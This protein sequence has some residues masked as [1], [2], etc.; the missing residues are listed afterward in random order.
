MN[1]ASSTVELRCSIPVLLSDE[2]RER[3]RAGDPVFVERAISYLEADLYYFCSGYYKQHIIRHLKWV[4]FDLS[5]RERLCR[6]VLRVV[7]SYDRV[8]FRYYCR[9]A[10]A[11]QTTAFIAEI[12]KRIESHD[13]GIIRRA[14]YLLRYVE[15]FNR[16]FHRSVVMTDEGEH[17]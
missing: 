12:R 5:Q 1:D 7:D 16:T 6:V 10:A 8:E 9:L 2:G 13:D 3:L 17:N 11:V 15:H 4:T 14:S